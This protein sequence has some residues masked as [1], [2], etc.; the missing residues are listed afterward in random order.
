MSN[1]PNPLDGLTLEAKRALARELIRRRRA[2][3]SSAELPAP[4]V[5]TC[6]STKLPTYTAMTFDMAMHSMSV[7]HSESKHFDRWVKEISEDGRYSFESPRQ[8]AQRTEV[9]I[10]RD[11]GEVI[12]ALNFGSYNY[13]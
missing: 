1:S 11:T 9:E 4:N 8:G 7:D 3:T 2:E 5:S 10:H 12:E 6:D 13:F